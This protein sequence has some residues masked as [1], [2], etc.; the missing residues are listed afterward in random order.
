MYQYLY[1]ADMLSRSPSPTMN[2]DTES[3]ELGTSAKLFISIVVLQLSAT[4][5]HSAQHNQK[6]NPYN[7]L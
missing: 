5:K 4:S 2:N 1:T 3:E 6:T 7:R